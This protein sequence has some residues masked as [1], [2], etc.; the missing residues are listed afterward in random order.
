M[1]L[2]CWACTSDSEPKR[3]PRKL[4]EDRID[5]MMNAW[6]RAAANAD[7]GRFFTSM[8]SDAV[9]I[10]TDPNE[11]WE[12][13]DFK[14]WASPHFQGKKAWSFEPYQRKIRFGPKGRTAWCDEKL[15][16]WMGPCRG[17]AVLTRKEERWKIAQYHLAKLIPNSKMDPVLKLLRK[18][19]P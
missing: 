1:F 9:Y 17:T 8:R 18:K 12:L 11:R 15:R 2:V 10:G 4:A 13:A 7:K 14:E 19:R 3:T 6:H 5:S 16:T